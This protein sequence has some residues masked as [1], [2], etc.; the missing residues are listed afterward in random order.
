MSAILEAHDLRVVRGAREVVHVDSLAI[1]EAETL[2]VLGPNGAGKSTLLL[3]LAALLPYG[4]EI[5]FR[6]APVTEAVAFRRRVAVV[7]QR[8]L[9]LDRSVR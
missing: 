1:E 5:R 3:A 9:L 4:G 2:A 8:P 6:G 7:F